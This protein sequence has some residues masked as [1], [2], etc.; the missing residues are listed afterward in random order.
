[1]KNFDEILLKPKQSVSLVYFRDSDGDQIFD[2]QEYLFGTDK[3]LADTDGDGLT[4]YQEAKAGWIVR[5]TD[6]GKPPYLAYPDPLFSNS[7][8]DGWNDNIEFEYRTN[9]QM[10][11]TDADHVDDDQ[12]VNPL[13]TCLAE[14]QKLGLIAWWQPEFDEFNKSY[15]AKDTW[16][17]DA[18]VQN[19]VLVGYDPTK[20][21]A[22]MVFTKEGI[23]YFSLNRGINANNQ[24]MNNN[25]VLSL[26]GKK[27]FTY[28]ADIIWDG[29]VAS[30]ED[31]ATVVAKG[32]TFALYITKQGAIMFTLYRHVYEEC[33]SGCPDKPL[34]VMERQTTQNGLISS[35]KKHHIVAAFIDDMMRIY[36]DG[37]QQMN[38]WTPNKHKTSI[39]TYQRN[40]LWLITNQD[41]FV[42]GVTLEGTTT[43]W[44]FKGRITNIQFFNA[45]MIPDNVDKLYKYGLCAP[46]P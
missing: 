27:D 30:G 45:K 21:G 23:P 25:E 31:R 12:D 8:T 41:P 44:P 5:V 26:T 1:M 39:Y 16:S 24:Y 33:W 3:D 18:P 34:N 40:F 11:D 13:G 28:V 10:A 42:I 7:D 14:K 17:F 9:P 2:L 32:S 20:E 4:D 37:K 46:A 29:E 36:V 19:G 35:G 22:D 15:F 6:K 43:K 38:Y